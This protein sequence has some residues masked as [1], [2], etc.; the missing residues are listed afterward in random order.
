MSLLLQQN[1]LPTAAIHSLLYAGYQLTV[2]D[3]DLAETRIV[4][5]SPAG[6]ILRDAILQQQGE[7]PMLSTIC[8]S[9]IRKH[10]YYCHGWFGMLKT[11]SQLP[12]PNQLMGFMN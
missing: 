11:V 9:R 6:K 8:R 10:L 3:F 5:R 4:S 12:L 1:G 7:V 2:Q